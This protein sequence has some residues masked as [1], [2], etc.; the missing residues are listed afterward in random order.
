MC[1]PPSKQRDEACDECKKFILTVIDL[2]LAPE[3]ATKIVD[4]LNGEAFCQNP[5]NGFITDD[6]IAGCQASITEFMPVALNVLFSGLDD[7]DARGLCYFFFDLC[8]N[9]QRQ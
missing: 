2:W 5:D 8:S 4:A 6:Q 3:T 1:V 7:T 9:K